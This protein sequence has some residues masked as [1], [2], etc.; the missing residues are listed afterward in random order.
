M[1][2][3]QEDSEEGRGRRNFLL[4]TQ[5]HTYTHREK[6]NQNSYLKPTKHMIYPKADIHF[7]YSLGYR[8]DGCIYCM[9]GWQTITLSKGIAVNGKILIHISSRGVFK[10]LI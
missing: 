5:T 2:R 1:L 3:G 8:R 7:Y 10:G 6:K 4:N 9:E